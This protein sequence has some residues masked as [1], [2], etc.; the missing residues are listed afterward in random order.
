VAIAAGSDYSLALKADGTVV[1]WGPSGELEVPAGLTNVA[2][3]TTTRNQNLA[4]RT[5]GTVVAW[6]YSTN[7]PIDL[8]NV[9]AITTGILNN[10]VGLNL[11]L[12]PDGTALAWDF[13]GSYTQAPPGW[14]NLVSISA[15]IGE[16]LGLKAD[17]TVISWPAGNYTGALGLPN[18]TKVVAISASSGDDNHISLALLADGTVVGWGFNFN[19]AGGPF[20]PPGLSNV[21]AVAAGG[22]FDMALVGDAPPVVRASLL[23]PSWNA[24]SFSVS[25]PTQSGRVYRLE[26]K[27]SL[28]DANWVALPLVAGNGGVRQLTD[29]TAIGAQ[30]FYRVRR[31]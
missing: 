14:T 6:G 7:V 23:S 10:T 26:Y 18:L 11:A 5:D 9:V 20:V 29:P 31:W 3:I 4:L 24:G 19:G 2:A 27:S 28:A 16:L 30:R 22:D 25:L 15:G 21:V 13:T 17:G 12:K 1:A 8:S